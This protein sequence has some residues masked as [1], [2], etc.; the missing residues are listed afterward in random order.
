MKLVAIALSAVFMF[1]AAG[2]SQSQSNTQGAKR[3]FDDTSTGVRL[4][5]SEPRPAPRPGGSTSPAPQPSPAPQAATPEVTGLMYY[6]EVVQ[7]SG[8]ALR[9]NTNRVFHSGERIR[10]HV[11]S[12]VTGRLTILQ[13]ENNG[14]FLPLFPTP[15]LRGGDN[16]VE[17]T[18]DTVIP[19]VFDN[20]PSDIRLLL[21]LVADSTA[22]A[23]AGQTASTQKPPATPAAA[24]T[25]APS[26][27]PASTPPPRTSPP[28]P[29]AQQAANDALPFPIAKREGPMTEDEIR[30]I[31]RQQT[32]SKGLKVEV[33]DSPSQAATYVVSDVR[34]Q[35]N[36]PAGTV[37][38]EVRIN[39][40]P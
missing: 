34:Q 3:L 31:L 33:D 40:Q 9:V 20:K 10:F 39:H 11:L 16:K 23:P 35:A 15:R 12:N 1:A 24:P 25:P 30:S 19:M 13:S 7:P 22:A 36:A 26:P 27:G 18:K 4:G 6:V 38:V 5:G 2:F 37:A 28:A 14:A 21:M 32:G 17:Q 8:Q 29:V